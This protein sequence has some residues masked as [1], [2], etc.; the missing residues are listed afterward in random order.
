MASS[1]HLEH[2]SSWILFFSRY[3]ILSQITIYSLTLFLLYQ[4][5][6]V[7]INTV[8]PTVHI[9]ILISLIILLPSFFFFYLI[10]SMPRHSNPQTQ[11][12]IKYV[13]VSV[14][15]V[16][17]SARDRNIRVNNTLFATQKLY[18]LYNYIDLRVQYKNC[19]LLLLYCINY[20]LQVFR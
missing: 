2:L 13:W 3:V 18:N 11:N 8:N 17:G 6:D 14:D 10:Y 5:L 16:Y 19:I 4:Q 9:N 7:C 15:K 1:L 20:R 12:N